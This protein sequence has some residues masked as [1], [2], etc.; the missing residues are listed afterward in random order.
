MKN[1]Y[2]ILVDIKNNRPE[3]EKDECRHL[4]VEFSS[5]IDTPILVL[6][7]KIRKSIW[8]ILTHPEESKC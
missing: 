3:I 7:K 2:I 8:D 6:K 1:D 4:K 5:T